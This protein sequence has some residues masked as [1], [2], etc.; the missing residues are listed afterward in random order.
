MPVPSCENNV[1]HTSCQ[2]SVISKLIPA[3]S[4]IDTKSGIYELFFFFL[5]GG[6]GGGGGLVYK[7]KILLVLLYIWL[8]KMKMFLYSAFQFFFFCYLFILVFHNFAINHLHFRC[9]V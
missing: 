9:F 3:K 5:R 6:G 2:N 1:D 4:V 8:A 7:K